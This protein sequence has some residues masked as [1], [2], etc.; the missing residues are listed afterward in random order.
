MSKLKGKLWVKVVAVLLLILCCYG[1]LLSAAAS[2][3]A[4]QGYGVADTYYEDELC[5]EPMQEHILR[6]MDLVSLG[7]E[8][9]HTRSILA[10]E[11]K[12]VSFGVT[13][14]DE[15]GRELFRLVDVDEDEWRPITALTFTVSEEDIRSGRIFWEISGYGAQD[16]S[17]RTSFPAVAYPVEADGELSME[18]VAIYKEDDQILW[19]EDL[20]AGSYLVTGYLPRH[21]HSFGNSIF[22]R[23]LV[24]YDMVSPMAVL[25]QPMAVAFGLVALGLLLFLL[26]AAGHRAG[27]TGIHANWQDRIPLDVYLAGAALLL[28]GVYAVVMDVYYRNLRVLSDTY[29]T[30]TGVVAAGLACCCLVAGLI[31]LA[32]LMSLATRIKLGKWWRNSLIYRASAG[33]CRFFAWIGRGVR[34]LVGIVPMTWRAAA[35]VG[36][37][38]LLQGIL[39]VVGGWNYNKVYILLAVLL[40]VLAV[41]AAAVFAWQLQQVRDQ[42]R[43]LAQ[44]KMDAKVD[45]E[46]LWADVKAH[47]E[48]LNA[49]GDGM[50]LAVE[51]KLRSER[52]KTEL[53]TNVSHDIK[54]PL[55]SIVNYVDLLKKEEL[56][57]TASEYLNILDRQSKRLKKL[58]EDLVEASKAST[59]NVAVRLEPLVVN[60]IIHQAIGD[61]DERLTAG[62]LEVVVNAYQGNVM[63]MADGRLLWRVLD[64]LFSN[65]CKYALAGT[66]VY[67]DVNDKGE[68]VKIS[69]K[70]ISREPLNGQADELLERFVRGDMSRHTEGSGLG[71]N[72]ASS[73]MELMGG[74]IHLS[75]DGD[76]FKAELT[77]KRIPG[78]PR[79]VLEDMPDSEAENR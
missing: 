33:V 35:A 74:S 58:T 70:N 21:Q 76:L 55:T 53:I 56:P 69:I 34:S 9:E 15:N 8:E 2:M 13:Q 1:A 68:N 7:R 66:R 25:A 42:G 61:Y 3:L 32:V 71:L 41:V 22:Q 4:I 23:N 63:A 78:A 49:I 16:R 17:S 67:V 37:F 38:L 77:V 43:A 72:I 36:G 47:G 54:T 30:S 73:L 24:V 62:R 6:Y 27:E 59:G 79:P 48:D 20:E 40:D 5:V 19:S 44:G 28:L 14:V 50:N 26:S 64:N 45:I 46:K 51:Q 60:E 11:F 18:T 29:N 31:L 75:T 57:E 65:I 39:A 10:S 12:N 52:L